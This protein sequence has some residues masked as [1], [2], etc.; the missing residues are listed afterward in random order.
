[1][2]MDLE[3]ASSHS[4]DGND[5]SVGGFAPIRAAEGTSRAAA[6]TSSRVSARTSRSLSRARSNN[7][8]GVDEEDP[9]HDTEASTEGELPEKDP[10]E[11]GWDGGDNDPMCPRRFPALRKW[12]IVGIVSFASLCV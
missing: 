3:K 8:Y 9:A 10:F 7:G 6:R 2:D 5:S 11:V 1:M 4:R 12:A